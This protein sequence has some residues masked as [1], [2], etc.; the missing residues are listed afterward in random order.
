MEYDRIFVKMLCFIS[1][2]KADQYG[3][4]L[5]MCNLLKNSYSNRYKIVKNLFM[6]FDF[7]IAFLLKLV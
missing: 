7:S 1:I 6:N 2:P 5:V 4:I 3:K